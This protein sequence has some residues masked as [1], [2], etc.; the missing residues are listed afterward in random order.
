MRCLIYAKSIDSLWLQ[1][2][3]PGVEPYLL[4]IVNKP[5]LEYYLDL[6][7][8]LK[9]QEVRI[10][11]DSSIKV[12]ESYFKDGAK[13]GLDISYALARPN[14]DLQSVYLKNYSFCKESEML[15]WDGFFFV[16][17]DRSTALESFDYS[18][19]LHC[20]GE[21]R[22]LVYLP[23]GKKLKD[24]DGVPEEGSACML[25]R[26]IHSVMDYYSLSLDILMKRNQYYVLPGY[27]NEKDIFLGQNFVYPHAAHVEAPIMIGNSVRLSKHARVGPN[28]I[29]GDNVIIDENSSVQNSIVYDNT[30]IGSDLDIENK[31]VYKNHLICGLTGQSILIEERGLISGAE[32]G[33]VISYFNRLIQ[34]LMTVLIIGVQI[35]PWLVLYLPFSLFIKELKRGHVISKNMLIKQYHDPEKLC[36]SLWGRILLRLSLDKHI[37]LWSVIFGKQ[38][39]V[40]NHLFPN[41]VANRSLIGE[42]PVYNPGVFS[43]VESVDAGDYDIPSFY[44]LEYISNVSTR[45]NLKIL[46]R[47]VLRRLWHGYC[48]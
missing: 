36:C 7:S 14:D 23:K 8:L 27:S 47:S 37:Q 4:K 45:F 22:R 12:I 2:Y 39:L 29:L 15:L 38:Y 28:S 24:M 48:K 6:V 11:S 19:G 34:F 40:G 16:Q 9:I 46:A 21:N 32:V 43:L 5:L 13:W 26:E 31:I 25:I 33:I 30:Y 18:H 42:L 10:V 3:L 1:E 35:I 20:Q 41:T 17:Y 44:E